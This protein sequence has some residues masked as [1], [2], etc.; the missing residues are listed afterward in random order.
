MASHGP[1]SAP[2]ALAGKARC[3]RRSLNATFRLARSPRRLV[4]PCAAG[5]VRF[6]TRH[7][8]NWLKRR[9]DMIN[10][11]SLL[12]VCAVLACAGC[13]TTREHFAAR[14]LNRAEFELECPKERIEYHAL[15]VQDDDLL[16]VGNQ[17]GAIGC[18]KRAVYVFTQSGWIMNSAGDQQAPK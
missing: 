2:H 13:A 5:S 3:R 18:D 11:K 4:V 7:D 15:N 10:W 16:R 9:H 1:F 8:Y 17:V 6:R 14:A 12:I